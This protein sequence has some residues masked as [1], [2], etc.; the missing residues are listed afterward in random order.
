MWVTEGE[1][2]DLIGKNVAVKR[3]RSSSVAHNIKPDRNV[4]GR[5]VYPA[6]ER[7]TVID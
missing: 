1:V 4:N 7:M 6:V 2:V 5:I 3:L